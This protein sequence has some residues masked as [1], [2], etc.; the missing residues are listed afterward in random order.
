MT[1]AL[2]AA[3][4]MPDDF[5]GSAAWNTVSQRI[6]TM[7]WAKTSEKG[8]LDRLLAEAEPTAKAA[9]SVAEFNDAMDAMIAKFGDSHFDFMTREDQGFYLF[10]GFLKGDKA[11]KLPNIGA[12]FTKTADGYTVKMV[13]SGGAAQAAGLRKGDLVT[14]IEGRPFSPVAS[15]SPYVGKEASVTY[16]SGGRT[17][18]TK[19]AVSE[20]PGQDMFL[21]ATK[22]SQRIVERDGKQIG[23]IHLWTMANAKFKEALENFVYGKAKDTD[24]FILDLRDGFGGRPEGYGDPFFRPE[25]DLE[26]VM[27]GATSGMKQMFGYQRPLIVIINPGSRSA[28]EVFSYII[29]KS[30]RGVLVGS[31]T[32]GDVLGTTPNPVGDWAYLEIPMVDV[33]VDG[34]RL[35]KN[36]VQAD[37]QV[38]QEFDGYGRDLFLE[39]AIQTAVEKASVRPSGS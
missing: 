39:K 12:W 22:K 18:T 10:D 34:I 11:A 20:I 17:K 37:V 26:W 31:H 21:E 1:L 30:K 36:P 19:V 13:L 14:Q 2:F 24:A 4:L 33:K 8:K 29:K 27:S 38:P 25:A 5:D 28:K 16:V 3:L 7:Y 9:K 35:E 23:Y 6:R 32:A 15:L